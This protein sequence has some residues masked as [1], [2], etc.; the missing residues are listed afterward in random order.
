MLR[1]T[2]HLRRLKLDVRS[3]IDLLTVLQAAVLPALD[4]IHEFRRCVTP[5]FAAKEML[6]G[7]N[8][9]HLFAMLQRCKS[10]G[11]LHIS[12]GARTQVVDLSGMLKPFA[13]L[14]LLDLS[15]ICLPPAKFSALIKSFPNLESATLRLPM[16]ESFPSGEYVFESTSIV[17]LQWYSWGS[18]RAEGRAEGNAIVIKAPFLQKLTLVGTSSGDTFSFNC[19]NLQTLWLQLSPKS[20]PRIGSVNISNIEEIYFSRS[21][22]EHIVGPVLAAGASSVRK[23]SLAEAKSPMPLETAELLNQCKLLEVLALD[24]SIWKKAALWN[25]VLIRLPALELTLY[26]VQGVKEP[27][28]IFGDALFE[29]VES[30]NNDMM[31][32]EK[33]LGT[34]GTCKGL[35]KL[36]LNI[37]TAHV[38]S[39]EEPI[40]RALWD[41]VKDF[42]RGKS[43]C[44]G[45]VHLQDF[46][47]SV[48]QGLFKG[49]TSVRKC[50]NFVR[51][52]CNSNHADS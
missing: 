27:Y 8:W 25:K 43:G 36:H 49:L 24:S 32:L 35:K 51:T 22:W 48:V 50:R 45:T 26:E 13:K 38:L 10:L 33:L 5:G 28:V 23:V 14:R 19:P 39:S 31:E 18:S 1:L 16:H 3:S 4:T 15:G 12:L 34:L 9:T 30:F 46:L 40:W 42:G 21:S 29:S 2:G 17:E 11:E 41:Y 6:S 52:S 20:R 7:F 37:C 47:G 44:E